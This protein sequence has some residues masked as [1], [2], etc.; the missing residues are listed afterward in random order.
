MGRPSSISPPK[1]TFGVGLSTAKQKGKGLSCAQS[2][3]VAVPEPPKPKDTEAH[4]PAAN[5]LKIRA[6]DLA[7]Y[8]PVK[9]LRTQNPVEATP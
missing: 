9:G 5:P 4:A 3:P 7:W 8:R 2:V 1:T 6:L